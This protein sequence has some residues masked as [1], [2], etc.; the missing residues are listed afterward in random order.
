M[1]ILST[2]RIIIDG[3]RKKREKY[4]KLCEGRIL[5]PTRRQILRRD[6]RIQILALVK[7][8]KTDCRI[9]GKREFRR[10]ECFLFF[11]CHPSPAIPLFNHSARFQTVSQ[12]RVL[13]AK[14]IDLHVCASESLFTGFS[15]GEKVRSD[16][17][18]R[19][20]GD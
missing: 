17:R 9:R 5:P 10:N 8:R 20:D 12:T 7:A 13:F 4:E 19:T 1:N 18:P 6:L 3:R 16:E 2:F 15:R 11:F 14:R